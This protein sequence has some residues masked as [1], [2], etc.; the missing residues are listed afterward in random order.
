MKARRSSQEPTH[1]QGNRVSLDAWREWEK[2][3]AL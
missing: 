1:L 2:E 3:V